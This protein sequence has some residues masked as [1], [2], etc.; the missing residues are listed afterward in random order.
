MKKY[1]YIL[2]DWNG[3]LLNDAE[4]CVNAMNKLLSKRNMPLS[5]MD[6]YKNV[7][8]F[9][10]R[11][12]YDKLGF[13]FSKEPFE[14]VSIEFIDE[15]QRESFNAGLQNDATEVLEFCKTNGFTQ[16]I[17]SASQIENLKAQVNHF[18]IMDY[19]E[20]ILGLDHIHATSKVEIGKEWLSRS[21]MD[22]DEII[23]IG[24]TIHDHETATELGCD[25]LL[26]PSG[27]QSKERLL[28]LNAPVVDSILQ[29]K[30]YLNNSGCSQR[31]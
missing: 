10:V 1:K 9:P 7:F 11:T 26:I 30:E 14:K 5:D 13:D 27:H 18:G 4:I 19:F 21:G 17:L 28:D 2:W 6:Y 8:G 29:V 31:R 24:D 3:T 25:V 20:E 22:S 23:M 16:F 12:Y 15:Y